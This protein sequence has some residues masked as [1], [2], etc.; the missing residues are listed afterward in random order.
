VDE[1]A[2]KQ[3][4]AARSEQ[5]EDRRMFHRFPVDMSMKYEYLE[6]EITGKAALR[7]ISAN[8]MGLFSNKRLTMHAPV[9]LRIALSPASESFQFT[10]E[11]VWLQRVDYNT[12]RAGV[13]FDNPSLIGVWKVLNE[14]HT[15]EN[16]PVSATHKSAIKI[17]VRHLAVILG[18]LRI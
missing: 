11:V 5:H 10:G 15:K 6:L 18:L 9:V 3:A 13:K 17:F 1:Y 4:G 7:D 14:Y 2:V 12:Y 8:G 16:N